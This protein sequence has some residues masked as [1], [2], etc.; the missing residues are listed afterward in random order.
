MK[1]G[2]L[3]LFF[4]FLFASF[5][6]SQN[7]KIIEESEI[8]F[9]Q[10]IS[11]NIQSLGKAMPKL[12]QFLNGVPQK[13]LTVKVSGVTYL[14]DELKVKG[15]L[16]EPKKGGKYPCLIVN[17]GG[18]RDFSI[19]TKE[20]AFILLAEISSWGYVVVASQ[21][22]GCAGGEGKEEFGGKDINDVLALI[23]LL[24]S[25]PSADPE[26]LGILGISRGGMMTY[27]ALSQSNRFRAAAVVGGVSDLVAWEKARPDMRKVFTDLIGGNSETK[28]DALKARSAFYWPDKLHKQTPILILHG[29]SDEKVA[30]NQALD[31]ASALLRSS[32][33]F[34][35]VMLE[36]GDH[37][38]SDFWPEW[39]SI[40]RSWFEKYLIEE[41]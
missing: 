30:P 39:L 35:L 37:N 10:E 29:T 27:L 9:T 3:I 22:R 20:E 13:A 40:V 36:G 25:R 31:M 8:S 4:S 23:P 6:L 41:L 11:K 7:G 17:R 12:G 28:P 19:W 1:K 15:F 34:R 21:Y 26:R 38:L 14:S 32:H 2:F 18:N 33:P 5:L 24:E 16:L